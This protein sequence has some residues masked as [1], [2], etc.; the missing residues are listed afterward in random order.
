MSQVVSTV[1]TLVSTPACQEGL[2]CS[3]APHRG[4]TAGILPAM[5]ANPWSRRIITRGSRPIAGARLTPR[6][7][8]ST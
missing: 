3:T 4:A 8:L 5:S 6:A 7:D 1:M 2:V